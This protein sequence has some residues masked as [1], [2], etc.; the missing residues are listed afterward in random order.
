[1]GISLSITMVEERYT[2]ELY[3]AFTINVPIIAVVTDRPR[4]IPVR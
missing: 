2:L 1:M 3:L 4:A